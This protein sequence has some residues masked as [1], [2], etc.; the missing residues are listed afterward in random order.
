MELKVIGEVKQ[1]HGRTILEIHEE[2]EA[3][4]EGLTEGQWII[5]LVWF[6]L[7]DTPELRRTLKVHPMGDRSRPLRGVFATRSPLRPNP[8]GKYTV[9][10][11]KFL[12]SRTIEID[13]IDAFDSTPIIDI[14]P[15][16]KNLDCPPV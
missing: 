2:F 14:K 9:K 8:I 12:N 16:I 6:H 3:A 13:P 15:F 11:R 5:L 1:K 7:S 4:L 10:I